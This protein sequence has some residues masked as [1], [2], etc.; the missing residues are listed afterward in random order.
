MQYFVHI[1]Y[2]KAASTFLQKTLFSGNDPCIHTLINDQ[3]VTGR[4]H[5]SGEQL[6]YN[7]KDVVYPFGFDTAEAKR[8][9]RE[10][11]P[12]K[13]EIVCLSSETWTGHPLSGGIT[14]RKEQWERTYYTEQRV[15]GDNN[16]CATARDH[17]TIRSII[18]KARGIRL[19]YSR[20]IKRLT[21][22]CLKPPSPVIITSSI[23]YPLFSA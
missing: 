5:K 13:A 10:S 19:R 6:F 22:L 16:V 20:G 2:P 4:Y 18:Q 7:R 8:V 14:G 1:G 17:S 11:T 9:L 21:T 23:T 3:P 12:D 15:T